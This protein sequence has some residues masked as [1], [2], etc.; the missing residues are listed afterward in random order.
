MPVVPVLPHSRPWH[1]VL[2][3]SMASCTLLSYP[4]CD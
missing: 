1:S 4:N 3:C 2:D